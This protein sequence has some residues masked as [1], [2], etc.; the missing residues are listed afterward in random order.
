MLGFRHYIYE[1][2]LDSLTWRIDFKDLLMAEP[3]ND[4]TLSEK[5]KVGM[6]TTTDILTHCNV[7]FPMFKIILEYNAT[8]TCYIL[9]CISTCV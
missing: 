5:L 4:P 7:G 2:K 9:F 6:P 1:Q 3:D 8:Y